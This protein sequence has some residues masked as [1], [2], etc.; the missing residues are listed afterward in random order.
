MKT[1]TL[2]YAFVTSIGFVAIASS[3]YLLSQQWR[4]LQGIEE[5]RHIVEVLSP[6]IKFVDALAQER[7]VYNQALVSRTTSYDKITAMLSDR[8]VVTNHLFAET[9]TQIQKLPA[10]IRARIAG[11]IVQARQTVLGAR[12]EASPYL[13]EGA[14]TSSEEART[15]VEHYRAAGALIDVALAAAE[16]R[17]AEIDPALGMTLEISRLSNDIREEAGLRSTLLS[18]YVASR[19]PLSLDD[20]IEVAQTTGAI[21]ITWD[22]LQRIAEEFGGA[23]VA[24]G[25]RHVKTEFFDNGDPVYLQTTDAARIGAAPPMDFLAWRKWTV[26]KL[27]DALAARDPAVEEVGDNLQALQTQAIQY[28]ASGFAGVAGLLLALIAIGAF[29][30][31]RLLRPVATLT[32]ALDPAADSKTGDPSALAIQ[33][34]ARFAPRNDEVGALA[35]AVGRMR[36][37][38]SDL[39]AVNER[40]DA[41]VENL[42]QGVSLYDSRDFLVVANRRF[43]E[44]YGFPEVD[45]LI[46]MS[47]A[48]IA[49]LGTVIG[50][51]P[52]PNPDERLRQQLGSSEGDEAQIAQCSV[53]LPNGRIVNVNGLRIP[54]GGWLSTHLDIT[55]RRRAEERLAF[56]ADHD[57]LTG[58]ANR[59][60]F[61]RRLEL[62]LE[63][64]QRGEPF[65]VMCLDLDRFKLV[66][67]MLG[68]AQGDELLRQVAHRLRHG[69]RATDCIARL[70][71]D[72]FALLVEGFAEELAMM[73]D[74]LIASLSEPYDLD[75]QRAEIS[76]SFGIA[77]GPT[78]GS[79]S[80]EL[81]RAAD[82]AMYRAKLDGRAAFRFFEPS[83][84]ENMQ[85]R[86][87]LE[88]DMRAALAHDE[89]ELHY[90]PIVNV[91]RSEIVAFEALLR[92]NHPTRG[93]ISPAD[94]IPLAEDCGLIVDLG[95]WALRTACDEAARWPTTI[96]VCVNLSP[97]QFN[98]GRLLADI[99]A[100]LADSGLPPWRLEFEITERVMLANTEA[101]LATLFQLR[102]LGV[103]IAMDDFGTG[104]S[105]LSYLRRFPFDKIKIDQSFIRDIT[106]D[107]NSASIVRAVKDLAHSLQMSTT[108]EG[109]ETLEQFEMLS[110]EGCTEIQG[111]YIS[112][113]APASEI[114][115]MLAATNFRRVVA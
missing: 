41:L 107:E 8:N 15:L 29:M 26:S 4:R 35:R 106:S 66:N 104:Y 63:R 70:G 40:F 105:S 88:H 33:L 36:L 77:I 78:D 71:G 42:P 97:R 112:R 27:S 102:E 18:R 55:R 44:L 99:V 64:A 86:R 81:L 25:V 21:R 14:P 91:E 48:A 13:K 59:A 49:E 31:R 89:F 94:F 45:A 17:L 103:S 16:R 108:A 75:G 58:L 10:D 69:L 84:D 38:A 72:E 100:A 53:D 114:G 46:G 30:E 68:H 12:D 110:G 39:Q 96:R 11:P 61:T 92:W 22:R 111:Y 1:R 65:S 52:S 28:E 20:R 85:L 80:R 87:S 23:K 76:A 93:R 57:V 83:M 2:A 109:V 82:L 60:Q 5:G 95:A 115:R 51:C 56:M 37:H 73:A 43:G 67:D 47:F 7:G 9:L 19:V 6:A 90:Q 50:G 54:G 24:A 74:R 113:P 98:S 3:T 79:N 32:A 101:T 34:A 62:A